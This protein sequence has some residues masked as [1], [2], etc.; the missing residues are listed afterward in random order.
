MFTLPPWNKKLLKLEF[1]ISISTFFSK[2]RFLPFFIQR[3]A[4]CCVYLSHL[5]GF[6]KI[7]QMC[8][9]NEEDIWNKEC[10]DYC[11]NCTWLSSL[12]KFSLKP[13][14]WWQFSNYSRLLSNIKLNCN[15]KIS[16]LQ[17]VKTVSPTWL[18]ITSKMSLVI[19]I[20]LRK[21]LKKRLTYERLFKYEIIHKRQVHITQILCSKSKTKMHSCNEALSLKY[22]NKAKQFTILYNIPFFFS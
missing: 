6:P 21:S 11:K 19:C 7:C 4:I 14:L 2:Y 15:L 8:W 22:F 10:S 12:W 17:T 3:E 13:F 5:W 1:K 18:L 16:N 9:K 20:F